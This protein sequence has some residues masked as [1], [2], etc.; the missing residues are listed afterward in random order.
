MLFVHA[1]L[2]IGRVTSVRNVDLHWG[3]WL[4]SSADFNPNLNHVNAAPKQASLQTTSRPHHHATP[5][6]HYLSGIPT[7]LWIRIRID[8]ALLDPDPYEEYGSGSRRQDIDRNLVG[9]FF[10]YYLL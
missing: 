1:N 7:V 10:T 4:N 8:L 5:K 9:M 2:P 3:K 6:Q